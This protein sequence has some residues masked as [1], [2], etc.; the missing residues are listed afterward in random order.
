MAPT[1]SELNG[2]PIRLFNEKDA[3]HLLGLSVRT[4]QSWRARGIGP[5]FLK[6]GGWSVRYR[7][8]D[9]VSYAETM[10][11]EKSQKAAG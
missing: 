5:A 8:A 9:I 3:A 1:D 10:V 7:V 2:S 4:L 6:L 11:V